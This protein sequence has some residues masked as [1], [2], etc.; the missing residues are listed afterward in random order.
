LKYPV[1]W[2]F[3]AILWVLRANQSQGWQGPWV[4]LSHQVLLVLK[5][6]TFGQSPANLCDERY[7]DSVTIGQSWM[8][9]EN[10]ERNAT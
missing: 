8:M 7:S 10:K 2:H 9:T 1:Q 4:L 6:T 5:P 3:V